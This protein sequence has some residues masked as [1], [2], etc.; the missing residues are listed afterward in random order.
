MNG[1]TE[2][3]STCGAVESGK[4]SLPPVNKSPSSSPKTKSSGLALCAGVALLDS[5]IGSDG[6]ANK[7]ATDD[8]LLPTQTG[9]GVSMVG[10]SV[11]GS[12]FVFL[13]A[14]FINTCNGTSSSESTSATAG[15]DASGGGD[16]GALG[17]GTST[18]IVVTCATVPTRSVIGSVTSVLLGTVSGSVTAAVVDGSEAA[19]SGL[20]IGSL[21]GVA[22]G[23]TMS[24]IGSGVGRSPWIGSFGKL[25][26][27]FVAGGDDGASNGDWDSIGSIVSVTAGSASK[28]SFFSSSTG[29]G[30]DGV[31][32]LSAA[33]TCFGSSGLISSLGNWTVL[34]AF[35]MVALSIKFFV[36]GLDLF[37]TLGSSSTNFA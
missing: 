36:D 30:V 11:F 15:V 2:A 8:A 24:T 18:V 37:N 13:S 28:G 27:V 26:V 25:V 5:C 12:A 9:N 1:S 6:E 22:R 21:S 34:M 20:L 4:G 31:D 19:S 14:S 29:G 32:A 23:M 17:V 7:S 35:E 3:V 33:D 16:R 10:A